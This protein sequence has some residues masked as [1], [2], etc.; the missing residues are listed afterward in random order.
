MNL[1]LAQNGAGKKRSNLLDWYPSTDHSVCKIP[2]M[3]VTRARHFKKSRSLFTAADL[4]TW[5]AKF[6]ASERPSLNSRS[7]KSALLL[8]CTHTVGEV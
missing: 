3:F 8:P 6:E 4:Q 5:V 1:K 7:L 2:S